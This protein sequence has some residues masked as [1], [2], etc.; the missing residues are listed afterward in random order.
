MHNSNMFKAKLI[1]FNAK[2]TVPLASL[3]QQATA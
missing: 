1:Y 3:V 2:S